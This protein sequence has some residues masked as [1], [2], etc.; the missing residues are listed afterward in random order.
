MAVLDTSSM[1]GLG[2]DLLC[3]Y[4]DGPPVMLEIKSDGKKPLTDSERKLKDMFTGYWFRVE[5][6]EQALAAFGISYERAP[7]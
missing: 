7:F 4:Q 6:F 1:G 5:S 2:C 3:R